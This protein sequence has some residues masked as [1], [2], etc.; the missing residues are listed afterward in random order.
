MV[1]PWL[2]GGGLA[3]D[4]PLSRCWMRPVSWSWQPS[5]LCYAATTSTP[6][7][8]RRTLLIPR[9]HCGNVAVG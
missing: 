3:A 9:Q 6:P 4:T 2:Q 7:S 5:L 8:N 1:G